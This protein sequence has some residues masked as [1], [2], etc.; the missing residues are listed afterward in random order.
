MMTGRLCEAPEPAMYTNGSPVSRRFVGGGA[1]GVLSCGMSTARR[2]NRARAP[3][4]ASHSHARLVPQRQPA[5]TRSSAMRYANH[6]RR[7][8]VGHRSAAVKERLPV[9]APCTP[10]RWG[11]SG[12]AGCGAWCTAQKCDWC[13]CRSCAQCN[14][15]TPLVATHAPCHLSY[16]IFSMQRSGTTTLCR[17]LNR[18][19][20][21]CLFELFNWGEHNAGLRW[22][23]HLNISAEQAERWPME[24]ISR[25]LRAENTT[26]PI[27]QH[28][29]KIGSMDG[30]TRVQCQSG[31]KLFPGH[32]ILPEAA[33]K[34]ASTCIILR[35]QNVSAQYLSWKRASTYGGGCW[36]TRPDDQRDCHEKAP[37]I[38]GDDFEEFKRK[39]TEWYLSVEK[40]CVG[41]TIVQWT[42]EGYLTQVRSVLEIMNLL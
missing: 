36:G 38:I 3:S 5:A 37:T 26:R 31:F 8:T 30:P 21:N 15:L 29:A 18:L 33:A 40:A 19:K 42:T 16:V 12:I 6:S 23:K 27:G 9:G 41:R 7:A 11:D 17:D 24:Y 32:H 20:M 1:S 25:V 4:M 22:G 2:A 34:L 35:R 28:I 39:Y 14:A 13:K 10:F